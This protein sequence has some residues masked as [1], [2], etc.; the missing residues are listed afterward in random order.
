MAS[1][2]RYQQ[3]IARTVSVSGCGYW[4]GL[5]VTVEFRPAAPDT[6]YVFVRRDLAGTPRIAA[7]VESRC[8]VAR[9]TVLVEG[10]ASVDMVEHVLAALAGLHID[11]C[12]IWVDR[13]EMPG[14]DGSSL[15]YV[16]ALQRA[17]LVSQQV[18]RPRVAITET[19]R[20][21]DHDQWISIGPAD[22]LQIDYELVY[23]HPQIGRQVRNCT[24]DPATFVQEICSARTFLLQ[25]EAEHLQR[26]GFG[27][28]ARYQDLLVFGDEGPVANQL[29]FPDE[30]VRHK[31]LD[32]VGD[33]A[34]VPFD[35][36]GKITAY[37]SG[38]ALNAELARRLL[39]TVATGAPLLR[40][41]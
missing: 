4:S 9:R 36:V 25:S 2:T 11:N 6:G 12:E 8:D 39:T 15:A 17:L 24:L 41:A 27:L 30:C 5:D 23:E 40:S 14:L 20:V 38:H 3:T 21:G 22:A 1:G 26:Q 34:L 32:V 7:R 35:I 10:G 37:R 18:P 13:A 19:L 16:R 33:L 31:V 29:R 28:R